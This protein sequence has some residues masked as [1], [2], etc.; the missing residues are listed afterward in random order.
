MG[1]NGE[2]E[3]RH[4][5]YIAVGLGHKLLQFG[6][7]MANFLG[8]FSNAAQLFLVEVRP[9]LL[10]EKNLRHHVADVRRT[11]PR[12]WSPLIKTSV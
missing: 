5:T 11:W 7:Q 6:Y 3:I 2:G 1:V 12:V 4:Y 9:D 10:A 8:V